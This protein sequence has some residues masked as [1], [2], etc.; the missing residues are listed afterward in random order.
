MRI[1]AEDICVD[2]DARARDQIA[3]E[4]PQA[5]SNGAPISGQYSPNHRVTTLPVESVDA[6]A[7]RIG[8]A[9]EPNPVRPNRPDRDPLGGWGMVGDKHGIGEVP[10]GEDCADYDQNEEKAAP[11]SSRCR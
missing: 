10:A 3:L 11:L 7:F 4:V 6:G 9:L 1:P 8:A 2:G 5:A